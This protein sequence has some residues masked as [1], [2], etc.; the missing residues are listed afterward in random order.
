MT[1]D[2]S[3]QALWYQP[4][5][6]TQAPY[7]WRIPVPELRSRALTGAEPGLLSAK[8]DFTEYDMPMLYYPDVL[9]ALTETIN[10]DVLAQ[11]NHALG[12]HLSVTR[13][14]TARGGA[15]TN[16]LITAAAGQPQPDAWQAIQHL[17][18]LHQ[19][20]AVPPAVLTAIDGLTLRRL[21]F[22]GMPAKDGHAGT[23]REAA[24]L[25][26]PPARAQPNRVPGGRRPVV[27]LIDSGIYPHPWFA[28]TDSDPFWIDAAAHGWDHSPPGL[29]TDQIPGGDV[30]P[31]DGVLDTHAGHGTFIAGLIRQIA[32]DARVLSMYAMHGDGVLDE[33]VVLDAL[34]WLLARVRGASAAGG[35]PADFVDVLN[36]SFGYYEH[37]AADGRHTQQLRNILGELGSLGVQVVASGG[38]DNFS[39]LAYPAALASPAYTVT[40]DIPVV[41][42]CA[43]NPDGSRAAYTHFDPAWQQQ[44]A[45]GTAVTSTMPPYGT[46]PHRTPPPQQEYN[47]NN[48][49]GGFARWG[50]TSFSAGIVSGRLARALSDGATGDRDLVDV[51]PDAARRRAIA[52]RQAVLDQATLNHAALEG[53]NGAVEPRRGEP[54]IA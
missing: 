45:P 28:G 4:T 13:R 22:I 32:P 23:K 54:T 34:D 41:A 12:P 46:A 15:E 29:P 21:Y 39:H 49:V 51:S 53:G 19:V 3:N 11:F 38:N 50:G 14:D 2:G 24:T 31:P 7:P 44:W 16:L 8:W 18:S 40:P 30:A 9:S 6:R 52:A 10:D 37:V 17:R 25:V 47:A 26:A 36:L 33:A 27:A 5:Q 42:V 35:D 20:R 1:A 48:L 43:L